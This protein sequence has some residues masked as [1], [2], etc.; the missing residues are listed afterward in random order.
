MLDDDS[1]VQEYVQE[2]KTE[3]ASKIKTIML[4]FIWRITCKMNIYVEKK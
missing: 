2:Y 4:P 1:N 3:K